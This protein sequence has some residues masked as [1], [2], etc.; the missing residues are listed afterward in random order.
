VADRNQTPGAD[1]RV[2][3]R[4]V[5]PRDGLQSERALPA[6]VRAGL[7]TRIA[8]AGVADVEAVSFVSAAAVPAMASPEE[9]SALLPRDTTTWWALVPNARGAAGALHAGFRHVTVTVSVSDAYSRKN[10]GRSTA[11]SVAALADIADVLASGTEGAAVVIDVVLSCCFGSPFD[12]VTDAGAVAEVASAALEYL[13]DARLTLADTTGT[14]TPRRVREVL[15]ATNG[16]SAQMP[17]LHL[18]DTRGTALVNAF[19]G[20]DA[21]VRHFD[22]ATGGLGGS[23]FAPGAGGNLAT[24][25]FVAVLD[26]LGV[27]TGIDLDALLAVAQD[28]PGLVGHDLASRVAAAGRLPFFGGN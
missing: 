8:A 24:E 6:D 14:A 26:D 22:T 16:M 25:Q 12:D 19:A 2:L 13:P 4:D 23:P 3:I 17:G 11:G 21:G 1:D 7:A 10:V 28:L 9:V 5:T 27:H 18:H 15:S 20:L